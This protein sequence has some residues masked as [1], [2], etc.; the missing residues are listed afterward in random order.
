MTTVSPTT[1][2]MN[3]AATTAYAAI[4]TVVS[5]LE[6]H[7]KH[8]GMHHGNSSD[9]DMHH[10]QGPTAA[11][12]VTAT[13][14]MSGM[15]MHHMHMG[16]DSCDIA[17]I[18]NWK[19]INSCFL[20]EGWHVKTRG[21]FAGTCIGIFCWVVFLV[22]LRKARSAFD[23]YIVQ[24]KA[25]RLAKVGNVN[26]AQN[27]AQ[28]NG[29]PNIKNLN[30]GKAHNSDASSTSEVPSPEKSAYAN[31]TGDAVKGKALVDKAEEA[32][33]LPFTSSEDAPRLSIRPNILEQLLRALLFGFEYSII[34]LLGLILMSYNGYVIISAFLGAFVGFL[35]FDWD[36]LP[37]QI[38]APT[39]PRCC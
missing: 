37:L 26:V 38:S 18:W 27:T 24:N 20:S 7:N 5:S 9:M 34:W 28:A 16:G 14:A 11:A 29:Q 19:V 30:E 13:D 36:A 1:S 25:R 23:S 3:M 35:L 12:D 32:G 15:G 6:V 31:Q 4:S 8:M 17:M 39:T 2:L 10:Y 22:W 33:V 21:Q